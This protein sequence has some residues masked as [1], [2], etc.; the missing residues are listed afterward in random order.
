MEKSDEEKVLEC[1][2]GNDDYFREL[3]EKYASPVFNVCARL[4]GRENAS[5][6]TQDTFLKAWKHLKK[7]NPKKACFKTWL[8]AIA[9]N[10]A[11]D[12]L[13]RKKIPSF[14]D[15]GTDEEP[16]ADL[17]DEELLPDEA[18]AKIEDKKLLEQVLEKLPENYKAILVLYYQEEMTFKEIGEVMKM[19]LNTVKSSHRRALISLRKML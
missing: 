2:N 16:F 4:A 13:R 3:V 18:L 14:S 17:P 19:P 10:T 12:Y 6:L 5:D 15:L 11:T 7:F 1:R 8:F 9:R